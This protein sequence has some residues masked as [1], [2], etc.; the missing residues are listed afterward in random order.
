MKEFIGA[1]IR[2]ERKK[3]EMTQEDLAAK[4]NLSVQA[5]S[6]LERGETLP[7]LQSLVSLSEALGIPIQNFF[8]NT[9]SSPI[10]NK[11]EAEL[12]SLL[13]GL[14]DRSLEIAIKQVRALVS[15]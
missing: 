13:Q 1:L 6:N 14:D 5:I 4:V 12:I 10:R 3:K 11:K 8:K 2:S 7:N 9:K 15:S